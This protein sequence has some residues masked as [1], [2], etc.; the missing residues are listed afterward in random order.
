MYAGGDTSAYL[1]GDDVLTAYMAHCAARLG[2]AY[3]RTPRETVKGFLDLLALLDQNPG[4][5]WRTIIGTIAPAPEPGPSVD[6]D[7]LTSFR[8]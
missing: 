7:D 5:D 2:D 1:V 8:L 4:L 6:D 3:F